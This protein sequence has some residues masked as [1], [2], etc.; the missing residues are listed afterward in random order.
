MRL[1]L[2][3]ATFVKIQKHAAPFSLPAGP[4]YF[5]WCL[6]EG[7]RGAGRAVL[8][9]SPEKMEIFLIAPFFHASL[10]S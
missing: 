1:S 9:V 4:E 7:F 2:N 10:R 3:T 8:Q 6:G 5:R